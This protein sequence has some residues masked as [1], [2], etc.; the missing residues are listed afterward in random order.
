[1]TTTWHEE[2]ANDGLLRHVAAINAHYGWDGAYQQ[3]YPPPPQYSSGCTVNLDY[4]TLPAGYPMRKTVLGPTSL[5]HLYRGPGFYPLQKMD[6]PDN[7]LYGHDWSKFYPHGERRTYGAMLYPLHQR[8]PR[9]IREYATEI[10]PRPALQEWTNYVT[11]TDGAWG[12]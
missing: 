10:L 11:V 6:V 4:D 7:T 2:R 9:E 8:S 1:M 3:I 5:K 12:R